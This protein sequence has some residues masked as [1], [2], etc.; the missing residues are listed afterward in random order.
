MSLARDQL[1]GS[2]NDE[3]VFRDTE[4]VAN[5]C[6]IGLVSKLFDVDRAAD[7]LDTVGIDVVLQQHLPNGFRYRDDLLEGTVTQGRDEPHLRVVDAA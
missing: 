3:R 5:P 7:Y 2:G 4:L 6:A 1:A